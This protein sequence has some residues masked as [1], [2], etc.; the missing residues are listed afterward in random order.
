MLNMN[1][2]EKNLGHSAHFTSYT[3]IG[4]WDPYIIS[5]LLDELVLEVKMKKY[6][7]R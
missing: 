6:L 4:A 7:I 3:P 5:S 2:V 1:F